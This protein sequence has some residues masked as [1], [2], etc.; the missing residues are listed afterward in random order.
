MGI[1]IWMMKANGMESGHK[2]QWEILRRILLL[3]GEWEDTRG[4][5]F[6]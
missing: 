2:N 6:L 3:T 5:L 1:N 4:Q